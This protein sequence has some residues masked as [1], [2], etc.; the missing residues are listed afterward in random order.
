V[1][2]K[3]IL[4]AI[5]AAIILVFFYGYLIEPRQI[6][7]NHLY[8]A[9]SSL[10]KVLAGKTALH[11]SD[12]HLT[13]VPDQGTKLIEIIKELKPDFVFLT[14]DYVQ[15]NGSYEPALEFLAKLDANI[16]VWAVMG[17]YD[18]SNDRKSCLLCH[19]P[20]TGR[21]T[22]RHRVR[23]LRNSIEQASIEGGTFKIV[24]VEYEPDSR[25]VNGSGKRP[26]VGEAGASIIL[27]HSPLLFDELAGDE[28]ILVLAGDTHGGQVWLPN[29]LWSLLGYEKNAKYSQGL[30]T[31]GNNQMY[32]SRGV[33]TS[34]VRFRLMCRPEITV[35]HF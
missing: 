5:A 22:K 15:W 2:G 21:P 13:A 12:L 18:Y 7:V 24:G 35:L 4:S 14:G 31:K 9:N 33:G 16:G 34:H 19:E 27:S 6:E 29:W 10:K 8:P 20:G 26:N 1:K 11:I 32:V 28:G 25:T 30:F 17:D 3:I 23:F